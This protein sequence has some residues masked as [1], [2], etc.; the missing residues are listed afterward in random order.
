[1]NLIYVKDWKK[2][3][4]YSD[5]NPPWIKL[6]TNTFQNYEFSRLHDASKLLA[7]CIW[8]LASRY[9]GGGVPCDFEWIKSQ[10]G[11]SDFVKPEHFQEL[12]TKGYLIDDSNLLASCKQS[13]TPEIETELET[14]TELE[15]ELETDIN[16]KL[17]IVN[18][19][20]I[21]PVSE[22]KISKRGS[23]IAEDWKLEG[24]LLDWTRQEYPV[25]DSVLFAIAQ[26]FKD[27]WLA[28]AGKD[29]VK[30]DWAATWRNWCRNSY[31]LKNTKPLLSTEKNY[32]GGVW[33]VV[34]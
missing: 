10:C 30:L 3:Q 13:A 24:E 15:K 14:E 16:S 22:K 19:N 28:K 27:Y 7:L 25:A 23:R 34:D 21:S 31:E 12:V 8:T 5:R 11:L 6:Q 32:E 4:H 29:G 17:P 33:D 2:F 9:E 18:K 20:I 26:G 1:M